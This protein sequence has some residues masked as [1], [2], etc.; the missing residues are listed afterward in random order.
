MVLGGQSRDPSALHREREWVPILQGA[1]WATDPQHESIPGPPRPWRV[2]YR[3]PTLVH[4]HS[5]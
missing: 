2:V 1:E 5:S 3:L 4:F